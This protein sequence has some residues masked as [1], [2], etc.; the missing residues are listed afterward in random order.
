MNLHFHI[1]KLTINFPIEKIDQI[2][3]HVI[4]GNQQILKTINMKNAELV[5][6][7]TAD[8]AKLDKIIT[9]IAALKDKVNSDP[10]VPQ[11]IVDLVNGIDA[12]LQAADDLND[13]AP[14]TPPAEP[15][16]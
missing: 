6:K 14:V 2:L 11:D 10:D 5:A 16:V 9:E 7:L 8:S 15:V 4:T 12:K 3:E 1:D 13:D